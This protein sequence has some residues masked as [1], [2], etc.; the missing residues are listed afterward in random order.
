MSAG[1]AYARSRNLEHSTDRD[2]NAMT[3]SVRHMM[4]RPVQV[5]AVSYSPNTRVNGFQYLVPCKKKKKKGFVDVCKTH[6]QLVKAFD[7]PS[8]IVSLATRSH[9]NFTVPLF[10][11]TQAVSKEPV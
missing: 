4:G 8:N 9:L 7:V 6:I 11:Q 2:A 5:R 3:G 10:R 1:F